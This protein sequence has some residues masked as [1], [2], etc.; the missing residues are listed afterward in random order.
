MLMAV[1]LLAAGVPSAAAEDE[2][3]PVIFMLQSPAYGEQKECIGVVRNE[4]GS[5]CSD[6]GSYRVVLYI[7]VQDYQQYYVKPGTKDSSG[8]F[9]KLVPDAEG[10]FRGMYYSYGSYI[11]N[12]LSARYIH[13][14]LVPADFIPTVNGYAAALNASFDHVV[15]TRETDGT[16]DVSP[17]RYLEKDHSKQAALP[18]SAD[19]LAIN[20]GFYTS[21]RPNEEVST[22]TMTAQLNAVKPFTDTVRFYAASGTSYKAYELAYNMGFNI[23]GNAWISGDDTADKQEMDALIEHANKGYLKMAVVGSET[24]LAELVDTDTLIRDIAYVRERLT[25]DIPVTTAETLGK[26]LDNVRLRKACDVLFVNSYP[27]YEGIGIDEAAAYISSQ[28]LNLQVMGNGKQLIVSETGWPTG[29]DNTASQT[30]A[31]FYFE[32]LRAWSLQTGINIVYFAAFDEEWK[33]DE[34]EE[35][36]Y[37]A[38][39][40]FMTKDLEL[41]PGY[42]LTGFFENAGLGLK[43]SSVPEGTTSIGDEA[44][45]NCTELKYLFIPD[46]VTEISDSAFDNCPQLVIIANENSYAH[47]WALIHSIPMLAIK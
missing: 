13:V 31:A 3:T 5:E 20:I 1:L 41:K 9:A 44:F 16:V 46:S 43:Y 28:L 6:I 24:Q 17:M 40:G 39:W 47:S 8:N 45:E 11:Q 34:N 26:L 19:K 21:G 10:N 18:V 29:G 35:G 12:D 27:I 15:I 22:A 25:V 42:A 36:K 23:I 33:G 38:Y 37:G 14:L 7:Q 32:Q 30:N 4:D 2:E